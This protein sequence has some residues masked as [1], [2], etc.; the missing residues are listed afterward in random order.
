MPS[1]TGGGWGGVAGTVGGPGAVVAAFGESGTPPQVRTASARA[2]P[3]ASATRIARNGQRLHT[4]TRMVAPQGGPRLVPAGH[5]VT[6]LVR[7]PRASSTWVGPPE[8]TW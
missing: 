3:G 8:R 1:V 7:K 6:G 4:R 2:T 5:L